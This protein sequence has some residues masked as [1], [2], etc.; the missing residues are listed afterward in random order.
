MALTAW[1]Y[2]MGNL[3]LIF[4]SKLKFDQQI[5]T[6]VKFSFLYIYLSTIS[7]LKSILYFDDLEKVV[8]AFVSS[9][10][11][12]CNALCLSV[13]QVSLSL[14]SAACSEFSG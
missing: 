1:G 10:L 3:G 2:F 12:Y 5:N 11:D 9:R 4:D 8:H 6:V 7:K 13:S 14:S